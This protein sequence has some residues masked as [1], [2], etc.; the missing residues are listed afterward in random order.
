[1]KNL[2]CDDGGLVLQGDLDMSTTVCH[3]YTPPDQLAEAVSRAD[4]VVSAAGVP[5][6]ITKD[7]V[8]PGACVIDVGINRVRCAK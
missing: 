4:V 5:N 6:L 8:K 7:I 3:R 1:M 2:D